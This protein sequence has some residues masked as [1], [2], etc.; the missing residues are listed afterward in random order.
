MK[1][2]YTSN[3]ALLELLAEHD[4]SIICDAEMRMTLSDEDA[5]RLPGIVE[6]FAPAAL[7]DYTIED[8]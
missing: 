4:I 3:P 5:A 6:E 2:I 1:I 8:L 7:C